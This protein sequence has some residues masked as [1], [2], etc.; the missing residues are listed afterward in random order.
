MSEN[1]KNPCE[2]C[3]SGCGKEFGTAPERVEFTKEMKKDYTILIPNMLEIHFRLLRNVF[4]SY[5]YKMELLTND[6]HAVVETGSKHVHNDT[7]YP[8][9]LVIGQ[10]IDALK[11]G[12][13]DLSKTALMI[14]Q[15]GGGCRASNY[16]HLLRKALIKAGLGHIPVISLNLSGLE[17]NS[18]FHWTLGMIRKLIAAMA[19]GDLMMLL[20]N[21]V[22]PYE[23][24]K[25]A[26]DKVSE[27]WVEKL[28]VEFAKGRGFAK[29]VMRSYMEKIAA[30]YA[31]VPVDRSVRKVKVGIVGE[32]Y[33]KFASLA[34][35]HLEEFLQSEGCEVMVPGLDELHPLQDRQPH[36][37]RQALRR[38]QGEEGHRRDTARLSC[39][40]GGVHN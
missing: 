26:A 33:V 27:E 6:S 20:A 39:G 11:S 4:R 37:G 18:G 38:K 21:Q 5:G 25:G 3:A 14:T 16:I 31:A 34:N 32:I 17:K 35:N 24:V 9:L 29:R 22:R 30:D 23:T 40:H 2:G 10:M 28:T 19:Y 1:E 8:A 36:R 7:C 13:Y 12:K 15:T